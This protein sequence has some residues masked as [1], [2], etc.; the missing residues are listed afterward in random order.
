MDNSA[1]DREAFQKAQ[2]AYGAYATS[3]FYCH[4]VIAVL[5]LILSSM[6]LAAAF[7]S[8][9]EHLHIIFA[10]LV[11]VLH[12]FQMWSRFE[13]VAKDCEQIA[14]LL[15]IYLSGL[16]RNEDELAYLRREIIVVMKNTEILWYPVPML[17]NT[18][19]VNAI[20]SRYANTSTPEI[21]IHK[22]QELE[23]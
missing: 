22:L 5:I 6:S 2:V 7:M 9:D 13:R 21:Q 11:T 14:T 4:T 1:L 16:I 20:I 10:G 15:T 8:E 3:L 19:D 23:V 17:S 18:P 12:S